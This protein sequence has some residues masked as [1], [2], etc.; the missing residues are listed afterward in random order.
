MARLGGVCWNA[1]ADLADPCGLRVGTRPSRWSVQIGFSLIKRK[2][3]DF[4][5]LTCAIAHGRVMRLV[6]SQRTGTPPPR[7]EP[8]RSQR[9]SLSP[10]EYERPLRLLPAPIS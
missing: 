10:H 1:C 9:L 8:V 7:G 4:P 6:P 3:K 2:S 5:I